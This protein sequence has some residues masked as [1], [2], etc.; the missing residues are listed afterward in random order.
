MIPPYGTSDQN[1]IQEQLKGL[2]SQ[3]SQLNQSIPMQTHTVRV[4]GM[5]GAEAYNMAPNSDDIL[6]DEDDPVIYFVMTDGAGYK[7]VTPY[8]I[9]RREVVTEQDIL[10]SLEQRMA[11]IEEVLLNGKSDNAT[12]D[13]SDTA[14]STNSGSKSKSRNKDNDASCGGNVQG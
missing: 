8:D 10:S 2:M 6:I 9:S 12:T 3:V 5:A 11:R 14:S 13:R 7:T 1:A 4:K